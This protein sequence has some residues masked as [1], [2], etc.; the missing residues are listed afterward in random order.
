MQAV[1]LRAAKDQHF[2]QLWCENCCIT[3]TVKVCGILSRKL[4]TNILIR[5]CMVGCVTDK[6]W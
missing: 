3:A 6:R 1:T 5:F 2:C 4:L